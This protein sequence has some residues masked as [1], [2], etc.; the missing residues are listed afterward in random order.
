MTTT[1]QWVTPGTASSSVARRSRH[2]D[3]QVVSRDEWLVTRSKLLAHEKELTRHHDEV[4]AERR[5]LPMVEIDKDYTFAGPD[6]K[7]SL[8][9]LFAGRR[10]LLIW[11]FMFDPSW[12][13][14]CPS[15]SLVIDHIGYQL[16]HLH[17]RDTSL[18]ATSRAPFDELVAYK[19]RM[20]W[21]IPWYSSHGSEFNYDFHVTLDPA[22]AA[23]EYNYRREP[24]APDGVELPMEAHGVSAFLRAADRVFHTYSSYGRGGHVLVGTYNW[25]DLTALGRQEDWEQPAGRSDGPSQHWLRRHDAYRT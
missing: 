8:P 6:G 24:A 25:P 17:A 11:H 3:P 14:G 20:G 5:R 21:A 23:V 16:D 13:E 22:V 10:Q 12:D 15:C 7:A 19:R 4:N 2:D 1:G 18:V 9:D